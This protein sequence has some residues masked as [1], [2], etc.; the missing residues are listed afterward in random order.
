MTFL[1]RLRLTETGL[2]LFPLGCLG[3]GLGAVA[4]ARQARPESML[5]LLLGMA[6]AWLALHVILVVVCPTADQVMLPTAAMLFALGAIVIAT[7]NPN[8]LARQA[9]WLGVGCATCTVVASWG[10]L[11]E[12]IRR[13]RFTVAVGAIAL[14]LVTLVIG[15]DPN[16]SGVR[17]WVGFGDYLFQPSELV[18]ILMV[19]FLAAYLDDR[20]ELLA[21]AD[22]RLWFLRLPPIPYVAPSLVM[23]GASL[24]LFL[25][26]RDLGITFLFFGVYMAMLY[27][28]SGRGVF[29]LSGLVALGLA[30][31]LAYRAFPVAHLRFDVWLD[32]WSDPS[33]RGYQ[34][35]QGLVAFAT[36]G[37]IGVGPGKGAPQLIPAANTDYPFAVIGEELGLVG[38]S[39]VIGLFAIL[40]LRGFQSTFRAPDLFGTYLAL[41]ITSLIAIQA[42]LN[43]GVVTGL[44]P[45][46]G[47]TL[48]FVSYGGTSLM[49][50]L[51]AV[52][53]LLNVHSQGGRAR[54]E[55]PDRRGR[56]GRPSLP[57]P[58]RG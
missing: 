23:L 27:A 1:A 11:V 42:L 56:N 3:A 13:Y 21:L 37:V 48:P 33:G 39:L 34:V 29:L 7:T 28:T 38:V 36:G 31:Y 49:I 12:L 32:P 26:Q 53:I 54:N 43:M 57:G 18:K 55:D 17:I 5:P 6:A 9:I 45:T 41:G 50:N 51:M 16:A 24:V 19:G 35:I 20:R 52:G 14:V 30:A 15:V 4:V 44:L 58:G 47:S 25:V 40:I 10:G 2:L 46:K 8:S 22:Y